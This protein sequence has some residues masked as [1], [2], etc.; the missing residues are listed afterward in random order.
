M[1]AAKHIP[2][3]PHQARIEKFMLL[4]GQEVPQTPELPD[5]KTRKL[6]A[7]LILEECLETID[8]LGIGI[9]VNETCHLSNASDIEFFD[10]QHFDFDGV[11]DGCADISVVTIGTLSALGIKDQPILEAVDASN[12]DKFRGDAHRREDGKWIKPSDWES[13]RF[14]ELIQEQMS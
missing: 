1:S 11:V 2:Q 13:P 9:E 4:A 5:L 12:L 3:T 8:A 10:E 6:R 14:G 7:K